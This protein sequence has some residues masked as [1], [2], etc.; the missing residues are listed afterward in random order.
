MLTD[1]NLDAYI[2]MLVACFI[3]AAGFKSAAESLNPLIGEAPDSEFVAEIEKTVLEDKRVLGLHDVLVH[4]YG[5]THIAASL[6]TELPANI[7]LMTAH[8]IIDEIEDK[9]RTKFGCEITIHADPIEVDKKITTPIYIDVV[10]TV[11][12]VDQLI[13]IK[14]FRMTK[15]YARTYVL[16]DLVFHKEIDSI[17]HAQAKETILK[18]LTKLYSDI[19]FIV[20]AIE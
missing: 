19:E 7:D 9:I 12:S 20:E 16:F 3:V 15:G 5:A 13:S 18:N 10:K 11:K 1:V 8:N 14:H 17:S 4:S 2:G 6:H